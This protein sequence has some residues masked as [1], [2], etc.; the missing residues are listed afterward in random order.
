[1]AL[2]FDDIKIT[3][4]GRQVSIQQG[5]WAGLRCR[6]EGHFSLGTQVLHFLAFPSQ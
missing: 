3:L 5:A 2:Q 4:S 1:M 6:K